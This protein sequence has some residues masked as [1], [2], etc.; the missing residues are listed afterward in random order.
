MVKILL[1]TGVPLFNILVWGEPL[2]SR[3]WNLESRHWKH[4]TV[5]RYK[6]YFDNEQ[7]G[8]GSRAWQTDGQTDRTALATA[9]SKSVG[10]ALKHRCQRTLQIK[11]CSHKVEPSCF[12]Y[13]SSTSSRA[14]YTKSKTNIWAA[15][16]ALFPPQSLHSLAY[17]S[18]I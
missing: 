18:L 8:R 15:V 6:I 3:T 1:S 16:I 12:I 7:R 11:T 10:R 17:T 14:R 9:C 13:K 5:V 4:C 2:N